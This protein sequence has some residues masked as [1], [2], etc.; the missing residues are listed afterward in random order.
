MN[1]MNDK[2]IA[3]YSMLSARLTVARNERGQGTLEYV[4]IAIVAAILVGAVVAALGDGTKIK[5]AITTQIDKIIG[6]GGE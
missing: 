4:G 6:F 2:M 1:T 3:L 5:E